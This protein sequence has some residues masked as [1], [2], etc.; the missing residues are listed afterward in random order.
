[1]INSENYISLNKNFKRQVLQAVMVTTRKGKRKRRRKGGRFAS[2]GCGC[3]LHVD[4]KS[5]NYKIENGKSID[6]CLNNNHI[7]YLIEKGLLDLNSTLLCRKCLRTYVDISSISRIG[8][9][10]DH[11]EQGDLQVDNEAID[12]SD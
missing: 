12:D 8:D 10:N 9:N 5:R 4:N 2:N 1:M 6:K 11:N 3:T 7:Q